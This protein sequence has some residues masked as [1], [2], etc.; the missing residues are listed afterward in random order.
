MQFR[1]NIYHW[2]IYEAK[3]EQRKAQK[4]GDLVVLYRL[5]SI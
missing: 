4:I 2:Y 5:L 1:P 3:M